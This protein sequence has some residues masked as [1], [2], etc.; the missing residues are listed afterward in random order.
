[1]NP[2]RSGQ[3]ETFLNIVKFEFQS[4]NSLFYTTFSIPDNKRFYR[5]QSP[6]ELVTFFRGSIGE[7][8]GLIPLHSRSILA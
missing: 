8:N 3:P 4:S 2:D 6:I 5:Y 1:M 7:R